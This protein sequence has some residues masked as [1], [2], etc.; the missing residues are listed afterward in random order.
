MAAYLEQETTKQEFSVEPLKLR[1]KVESVIQQGLS[2]MWLLIDGED[3]IEDEL[4]DMNLRDGRAFA[5]VSAN[6]VYLL[7]SKFSALT[8]LRSVGLTI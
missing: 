4:A 3:I 2:D 8:A 6:Q 5:M 1:A 7:G